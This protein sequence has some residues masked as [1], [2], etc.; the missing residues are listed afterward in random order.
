MKEEASA[1]RSMAA[2]RLNVSALVTGIGQA[3]TEKSLRE[4]LARQ[5]PSRVFT[6]GFAGGL[7]PELRIGEVLFATADGVLAEKLTA[8]GAKPAVFFCSSRIATTVAEKS[9][10]RRRTGADA[11]EMESQFIQN[12]C[13]ERGI[14]CATLRAISDVAGED[15]PLDFNRLANPDLSLNYGRLALAL[16][17]SPGK[18]PA[19]MRLQ[20][21]SRFAAEQLA[22]VL[23]KVCAD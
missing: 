20:K 10:L 23:A 6:C 16:A 14:P 15:L 13:Q 18:I 1:F 12:I 4:S 8:T 11:V 19:L 2:A 3:N 9:E 5:V 7:H 17:K 22:A 21:N